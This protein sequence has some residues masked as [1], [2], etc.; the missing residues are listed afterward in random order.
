MIFLAA[1]PSFSG[2]THLI[3]EWMLPTLLTDP[4]KITTTLPARF[5]GAL[6]DD[7]SSPNAPAGQYMVGGRYRDVAAWRA[8]PKTERKRVSCFD[9]AQ[10]DALHELALALANTLLV[11]DEIDAVFPPGRALTPLESEVVQRGRHYGVA[12]VG[13]CRRLHNVHRDLR[14]NIQGAW[15]GNLSEPDD[16]RYAS[17]LA[18][19]DERILATL[20]PKEFVEYIRA[21]GAV[22]IVRI[23]EGGDVDRADPADRLRELERG[24]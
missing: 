6:I 12:V 3:R 4:H 18:G 23:R 24:Q 10:P 20:A 8:T 15:I 5:R 11:Y 17:K 9:Q 2:K 14:A 19:V 16:R 22:S 21:T 7:P 13:T 1:G